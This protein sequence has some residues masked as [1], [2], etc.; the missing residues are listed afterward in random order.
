[1]RF[2][3]QS[4]DNINSVVLLESIF[5]GFWA[6]VVVFFA[7]EIGQRFSASFEKIEYEFDQ[8]NWYLYPIK[9]QRIVPIM[10][11]NV[12]QPIAI[13]FFGSAVCSRE[14]FKKVRIYCFEF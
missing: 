4:Q 1:M 8:L 14:Q 2:I 3:F 12:K 11:V 13:E 9:L 6:F 10:I 5:C 7:N